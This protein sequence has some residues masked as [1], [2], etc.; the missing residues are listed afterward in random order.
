MSY[1]DFNLG[2]FL[3]ALIFLSFIL[4]FLTDKI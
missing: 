4:T 2:Q 3:I 1:T